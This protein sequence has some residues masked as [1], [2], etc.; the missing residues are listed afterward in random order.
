MLHL[1][2]GKQLLVS[3]SQIWNFLGLG[4]VDK[5]KVGNVS[6]ESDDDWM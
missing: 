1:E 2:L 5:S 4:L 6:K 3:D